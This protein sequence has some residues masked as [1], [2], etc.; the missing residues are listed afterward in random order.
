MRFLLRSQLPR[1]AWRLALCSCGMALWAASSLH[2]AS[3]QKPFATA[4]QI[5]PAAQALLNEAIQAL[6]GPAFLNF[7]TMNT[8]GRAFSI[9]DGVT[10]GF[11]HYESE[12][13][14]PDKRRLAYGLGKRKEIT[15]INNGSHGWEIDRYG[16]IEQTD[17][18]IRAWRLANRYEL[19][20]V[21]RRVI[22]EPGTLVQ[23]GGQDFVNNQAAAIVDI[24]DARQA[25]V[26]LYLDTGTHLP[27][28]IAYRLLNPR[29]HEWDDYVE[30]YADYQQIQDIDT[31]MHLVRYVN[32]ERAAETFRFHAQYG[33]T[34]P[35]GTF[36]PPG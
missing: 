15:L 8:V 25:D 27:I 35:P 18:Q 10:A 26:K 19:A 33:E 20:N 31:P 11:V 22:H 1:P 24:L 23:N 13:E 21:L 5:D 36:Q 16:L 34:Y 28:R 7:K 32:G 4:S 3:A 14:F 12:E 17:K 6:G 2:L 30:V 29:T 9:T